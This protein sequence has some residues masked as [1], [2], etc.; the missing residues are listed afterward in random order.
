MTVYDPKETL[1][2]FVLDVSTAIIEWL[3]SREERRVNPA[4]YS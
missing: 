4:K 1:T 2:K 3:P